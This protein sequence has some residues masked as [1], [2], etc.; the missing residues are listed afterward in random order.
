MFHVEGSDRWGLEY[1]WGVQPARRAGRYPRRV[2]APVGRRPARGARRAGRVPRPSRRDPGRAPG[3]AHLPLRAVRDHRAEAAG[4]RAQ[5]PRGRARRPAAPR[6]LRRPLRH[7]PGLG[8][9]LAA[10]VQH[11][12]ARAALHGRSASRRGHGGDASIAEYHAY[13]DSLG[14]DDERGREAPRQPARLQH[15]GLRVDAGAARLAAAAGR[16]VGR[17]AVAAAEELPQA[18]AARGRPRARRA[19]RAAAG[20]EPVRAT[21][22][23]ARP[24]EQAWAMLESRSGYYKREDKPFWWAH[25]DRLRARARGVGRRQGR[26]AGRPAPRSSQAWGK[27]GKQTARPPADWGS[28]V[29]P[30]PAAP[31]RSARKV[32]LLYDVPGP[33]KLTVPP[34]GGAAG[35]ERLELAAVSAAR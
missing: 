32:V 20:V 14:H 13:R 2:L 7:G 31:W 5:D 3:H 19:A 18:K 22:P 29:A 9:G 27:V 17:S 11:Q 35:C 23:N 26:H 10:V 4:G 16:P 34:T 12:E 24:E 21:R 15:H 25:F 33:E 8:A 6:C 30:A 1:L 28:P